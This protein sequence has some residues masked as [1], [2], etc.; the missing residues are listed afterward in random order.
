MSEHL[1]GESAPAPD[2]R[3]KEALKFLERDFN[4]SFE[5]MRHYDNQIIEMAKLMPVIYGGMTGLAL[6][7][8]QLGINQ[9]ID[10][11]YPIM[12]GLFA[13]LVVGITLFA[14]VIRTR[15]YFVHVCRYV[16]EHRRFFLAMKPLGF[17]NATGM[18]T[19]I[20]KPPFFDWPSSH[21]MIAGAMAFLNAVLGGVAAFIYFYRGDVESAIGLATVEV[22]VVFSLQALA[23]IGYL[24]S[25][26]NKTADESVFGNRK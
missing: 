26:D 3:E 9:R 8:N 25:R 6:G 17:P 11:R 21:L 15:V 1:R 20:N 23:G 16:N 12:A 24:N 14:H 22:A 10:L 4:Q 13:A 2:N 7:F 19:S 18:Y 5:Q